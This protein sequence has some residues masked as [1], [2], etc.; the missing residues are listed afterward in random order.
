LIHDAQNHYT[1]MH[2][3]LANMEYP[4][5]PV[6]L[7]VIR[8]YKHQHTYDEAVVMQIEEAKAQTKNKSMQDVLMAGA[9]WEIK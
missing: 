9:I 7:G 5:F 2:V 3:M 4:K 8:D 6:A 1:G